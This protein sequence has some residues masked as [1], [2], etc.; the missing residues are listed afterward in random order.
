MNRDTATLV[1]W[2]EVALALEEEPLLTLADHRRF[3]GRRSDLLLG[4]VI[5]LGGGLVAGLCAV[6]AF[7][8]A[9]WMWGMA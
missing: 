3:V 1:S 8:V 4:V 6:G 5:M 2:D 9:R 7:T